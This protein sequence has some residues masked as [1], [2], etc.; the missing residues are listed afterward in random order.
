M[1][2]RQIADNILELYKTELDSELTSI[3]K[4]WSTIT[5]DVKHGGFYGK[6]DNQN[7][8]TAGAP[9][10][11][12]LNARILWSFSA[13]YNLKHNPA[14]LSMADRAYQYIVEH[15]LDSAY[16]GVYWSVDYLGAPLDSK[17]QVYAIAFSIYAFSEYYWASGNREAKK[18]AIEL[19]N[20]LVEK[21][22][23]PLKSGYFEAFTREWGAIGDLRLSAKDA[24]EKKTMNT[25]LHVLEGYTNLYR[26]WPDSGLKVQIE[27]LIDNFL[28]YFIDEKTGHLVLFFDENWVPKSTLVSYGHDIE[29]TW[30]LQE[31]AEVI[32]NEEAIQKIKKKN[33]T[34]ADAT[35]GGLDTDGGL[36]YEYEPA[37]NHLIK[38]KHWWVQAEAMVGFFNTW[39]ITGDDKYLNASIKN[40]AFIKDKILDKENGEWFWGINQNGELMPGEDKAGLWKCPYHN[41]RACIELIKRINLTLD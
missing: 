12:V 4:Y 1:M 5:P 28:E 11:S 15:M 36:W 23:D 30:L 24:N 31:A 19:Y 29:A 22:C 3:L 32:G 10:G 17:K 38:E 16:G 20:L 18:K 33:I 26:I 37:E 39:Q 2:Q 27:T 21:A 41:S 25:H 7:N 8:I 40:W 34:I 6:I 14:Y 13:A 35:L 9:K